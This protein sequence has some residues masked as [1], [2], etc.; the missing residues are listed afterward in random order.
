MGSATRFESGRSAKGLTRMAGHAHVAFAVREG[1]TRLVA[2]DQAS[3]LRVLFPRV[4]AQDPPLAALAVVSGGIVG[5]DR[6]DFSVSVSAGGKAVAAG[7]AAEKVYRSAGPDSGVDISLEVGAGGWLEWLP[8]ETILFDGSRLVRRTR[9][10]VE[11]TG[12]VLAG[13]MLVFG[14]VARG[15]TLRRGRLSERFEVRRGGRLAW[16]DS[17]RLAGDISARLAS[18]AGFGGARVFATALY[19]GPDG[20]RFLEPARAL[21]TNARGVR[22]GA[23][24]VHGVLVARWLGEDPLGVRRSF[25]RYLS[26][27]RRAAGGLPARLPRLWHV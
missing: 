25:E 27:L 14:R 12:R 11:G 2:L 18:P 20:P 26:A 1:A 17:L 5:G 19:V 21:A 13:E 9:I 16:A 3:P 22:A 6:L 4:D 15:E 7:Q 8:Q 10:E 23:T 24:C